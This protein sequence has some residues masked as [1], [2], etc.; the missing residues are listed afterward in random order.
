MS[1]TRPTCSAT[2]RRELP[3]TLLI[4]V[5]GQPVFFG[6]LLPHI[7]TLE[8]LVQMPPACARWLRTKTALPLHAL[9]AT[10]Q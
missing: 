9:L 6:V 7:Q 4:G 5:A 3:S 8:R 10:L 1:K 2:R